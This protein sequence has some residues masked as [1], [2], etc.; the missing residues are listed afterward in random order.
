MTC[1]SDDVRVIP[2]RFLHHGATS[3]G[4]FTLEICPGICSGAFFD[5]CMLWAWL[6]FSSC[7]DVTTGIPLLWSSTRNPSIMYSVVNKEL[8]VSL[9]L[10]TALNVLFCI[11][12][13]SGDETIGLHVPH[14]YA[15][16]RGTKFTSRRY[17]ELCGQFDPRNPLYILL[18]DCPIILGIS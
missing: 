14:F 17:D 2:K 3:D 18:N 4:A 10:N 5:Y 11:A 7:L 15:H 16:D 9:L 6:M 13:D 1:R 8:I 12:M